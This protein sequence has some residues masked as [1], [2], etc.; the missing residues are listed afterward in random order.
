MSF[1]LCRLLCNLLFVCGC[2]NWLWLDYIVV[3]VDLRYKIFVLYI[4]FYWVVNIKVFWMIIIKK[5]SYLYKLEINKNKIIFFWIIV[6]YR[7][8]VSVCNIKS[9]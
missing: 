3:S 5:V 4:W 2:E 7:L 8:I 9:F 6:R 1:G